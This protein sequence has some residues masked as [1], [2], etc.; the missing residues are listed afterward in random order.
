MRI[1]LVDSLDNIPFFSFF[2]QKKECFPM[3][4]EWDVCSSHRALCLV[5]NNTVCIVFLAG[6]IEVFILEHGLKKVH[7]VHRL[8]KCDEFTT[9]S[10][11]IIRAE[12]GQSQLISF[13]FWGHGNRL[14]DKN[15]FLKI[16]TKSGSCGLLFINDLIKQLV[17]LSRQQLKIQLLL[18]QCWAHCHDLSLHQYCHNLTVDYFTSTTCPETSARRWNSLVTG[19][20]MNQEQFESFMSDESNYE[21]VQ[22]H[23]LA[24]YKCSELKVFMK[25]L[26]YSSIH[27]EATI[28]LLHQM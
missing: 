7:T 13:V 15:G 27:V 6:E 2:I 21:A 5:I 18:T 1:V 12:E 10:Q 26:H 24:Q 4:T 25:Y 20:E 19:L 14:D 16:F 11:S 8:Y 9:I 3:P 22:S 17:E 23:T 28:Y